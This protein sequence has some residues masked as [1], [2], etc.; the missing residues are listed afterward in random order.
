[1]PASAAISNLTALVSAI[2]QAPADADPARLARE[3]M[4]GSDFWWKQLKP[5]TTPEAPWLKK[6][7]AAMLDVLIRIL[8]A[9]GSVIGWFFRLFGRFTGTGGS[10]GSVLVW[11]V[12][13]AII[14]WAMWKLIPLFFRGSGGAPPIAR[15]D[16]LALETLA[17]ASDLREQAAHAL[18]SGRHAE[19]IRLALLALIAALEQQGLLRYDTTRTNREYRAELRPRP[20]LAERFGRLAVIYERVWY[21]REPAAREQAE[22][23][24]RLCALAIDGEAVSPG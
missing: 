14:A 10:G 16:A 8:E 21:G 7:G 19:A 1:M 9:V 13:G 4:G 6:L 5:G 18:A 2:V 12:A 24:I 22:E 3:V 23:S 20:D 11:I 17:A 15:A